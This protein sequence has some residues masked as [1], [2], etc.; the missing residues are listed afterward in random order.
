M[1]LLIVSHTAHYLTSDGTVVGWGPTVREIDRLSTLFDEVIHV[2]SMHAGPPPASSL[3]YESDR[4]RLAAVP[5]SGGERLVDKLDAISVLPEYARRIMQEARNA[6]VLHVRCP[7]RVSLI[8]LVLLSILRRGRPFWAKYAGNWRPTTS[9]AWSYTLQRFWLERGLHGGITT[10]NGS[11]PHQPSHVHSFINPCLTDEELAEGEDVALRKRLEGPVRLL[12]VGRLETPKGVE[13]AIRIA[14]ILNAKGVELALDLVG[15]GPERS[16]F[17]SLTRELKLEAI[18]RFHGWLPRTA[19]A[20]LYRRAHVMLFPASSSE[21]WPKVLS[22]GMAYGVVPLAGDVS[23]IRQ[24]FSDFGVG[25]AFAPDN[26][27]SFADAISAYTTN[28][29]GWSVESQRAVRAA[30]RFGYSNFVET[31]RQVLGIADRAPRAVAT[32]VHS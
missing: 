20:P 6:D 29:A 25:H 28:P 8:G 19:L 3:P 2:A 31:V 24:F 1:K 5:A 14:A 13:R 7:A 11:W 10:V 9:E 21:G 27:E 12:Y 16:R 30:K 18:I 22:E 17:E 23:C 4:V 15:D 32:E 26:L